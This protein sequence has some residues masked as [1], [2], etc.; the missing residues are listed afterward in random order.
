MNQLFS[1]ILSPKFPRIAREGETEQSNEDQEG[2]KS[3]NYQGHAG[4]AQYQPKDNM[5]QDIE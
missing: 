1:Y 4:Q 2:W 5:D 3:L